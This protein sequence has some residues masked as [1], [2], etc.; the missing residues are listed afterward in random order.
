[1]GHL[2]LDILKW[3][4]TTEVMLVRT[5]YLTLHRKL[6]NLQSPKCEKKRRKKKHFFVSSAEIAF[7]FFSIVKHIGLLLP[8]LS[9]GSPFF[10]WLLLL[11][12][13]SWWMSYCIDFDLYVL[14]D[15]FEKTFGILE[16]SQEKNKW[17]R[18]YYY[19]EF[20]RSFFGRIQGYQKVLS[21]LSDL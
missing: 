4:S 19:D 18:F 1:M 9:F 10:L 11:F 14:L 16:F 12:T 5:Y 6:I 15:N 21:K 8:N 13:F 17:I 20:V 3:Y 2:I 7:D